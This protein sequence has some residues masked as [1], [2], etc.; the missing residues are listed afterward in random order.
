MFVARAS[1]TILKNEDDTKMVS[2]DRY[3]FTLDNSPHN[4]W[5]LVMTKMLIR[6]IK[7]TVIKSETKILCALNFHETCIFDF[8]NYSKCLHKLRSS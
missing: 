7:S 8:S 5:K 6:E 2:A 3:L 4:F 1:G